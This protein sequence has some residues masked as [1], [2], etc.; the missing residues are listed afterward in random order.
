[1]NIS[2]TKTVDYLNLFFNHNFNDRNCVA[3]PNQRPEWPLA[4]GTK[5]ALKTIKNKTTINKT[6]HAIHMHTFK[7]LENLLGSVS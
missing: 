3:L 5:N 4:F 7:I 2:L 6:K 1:M